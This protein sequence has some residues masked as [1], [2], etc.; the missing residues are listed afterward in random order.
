MFR[1]YFTKKHNSDET[2]QSLRAHRCAEQYQQV[3]KYNKDQQD[4]NEVE[5]DEEV[6]Q[7]D[8]EQAVEQ[9]ESN[10]ASII[11]V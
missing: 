6:E 8:K 11:K 5:Q 2:E 1:L 10:E 9:D 3:S 4:H 7:D